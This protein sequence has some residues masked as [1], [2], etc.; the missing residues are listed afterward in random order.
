[1][2]QVSL[3]QAMHFYVTLFT[4]TGQ[5]VS[6]FAKHLPHVTWQPSEVDNE[7]FHNRYVLVYVDTTRPVHMYSM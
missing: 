4:G 7:S 6:Y 1:M 3:W 2:M 5:H